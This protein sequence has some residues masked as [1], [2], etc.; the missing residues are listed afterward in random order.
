MILFFFY[1]HQDIFNI[2]M[3]K[4]FFPTLSDNS[5]LPNSTY[6]KV[7]ENLLNKNISR[8][9][10][11]DSRVLP[12]ENCWTFKLDKVYW[13]INV[14]DYV[15]SSSN[16]KMLNYSLQFGDAVIG[17]TTL[18]T[19]QSKQSL[20]NRVEI[21]EYTLL[22]LIRTGEA[23]KIESGLKKQINDPKGNL[24]KV[25]VFQINCVRTNGGRVYFNINF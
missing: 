12:L 21:I 25:L 20:Y 18:A 2:L 9:S 3:A 8:V 7:T 13:L 1:N 14:F 11:S 5:N 17:S 16:L 4:K 19:M 15:D 6:F 23:E 24:E 22:P 10:R